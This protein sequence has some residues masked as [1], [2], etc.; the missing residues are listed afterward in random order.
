MIY[1]DLVGDIVVLS[2]LVFGAVACIPRR[3]TP[4]HRATRRHREFLGW[5]RWSRW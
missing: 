5:W 2:V 3:G 4:R 1:G